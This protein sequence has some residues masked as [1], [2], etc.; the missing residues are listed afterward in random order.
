MSDFPWDDHIG[1]FY[2]ADRGA[3]PD[4]MFWAV[5]TARNA[6]TGGMTIR[7]Y[8]G[9]YGQ[10][11]AEMRQRVYVLDS[12]DGPDASG[13]V[14]I[15]GLDPLLLATN[16]KAKFP[17]EMDVRL[18]DAI[19][20]V[21]ATIRVATSEPAKLTKVYGNVSGVFH[22][23]IGNEVF[24]YTGVTT[25]E[26]GIYDLT[27]VSRA[28]V[29]VAAAANP[30][31]RCQRVGRYV[32]IPT[33]EIGYDLLVNHTPLP[34]GYVNLSAWQAEGDTYLPTLRSTAWVCEP[35]LVD[36]L[37]GEVCQQGQFYF[38]WD[39]Y[40]QT[41]PMLAVRPPAGPVATL[42]DS[43]SIVKGSSQLTR[44]PDSLI[45][46]VFVY[47]G[48][49]NPLVSRTEPTNYSTISGRVEGD[50]EHPNAAGSPRPLSIFARFVNTEAHAVQII[51]RILSRYAQVPRFLT[52][53]VDAKDR[54]ITVG[55]VCDVITREI[56]DTE[57]NLFASRWQVVS[58]DE[59]RA[60]E[61]YMIDLQTYD[62]IG[63]FGAWM[64]DSANTY[65][66]ATEA[67]KLLGAWW[68]ADDG[69]YPGGVDGYQ[70]N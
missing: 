21:Q 64:A 66:S 22:M 18:T 17:E 14:K 24:G 15:T 65:E 45:S 56:V 11:L 23:R 6:F 58:W 49:I 9:Y 38:W 57:G 63:A 37:L 3:L 36:D 43:A 4:R 1:D 16:R 5:W 52:L 28:V 2:L 7:V 25:V 31:T 35:T 27:G 19:D 67:E 51:Q 29:G 70:W 32:D 33:W 47:Y 8:D 50:V 60:G 48:Q 44:D 53:H 69:T 20:A 12:I 68:A 55:N 26:A 46:R 61:V 42:T 62:Y 41:V 30:E 39:E 54:T 10:T 40:G 13:S 59:V 34:S